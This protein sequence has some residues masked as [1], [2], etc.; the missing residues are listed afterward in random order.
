M[1]IVFPRDLEGVAVTDV[2]A[3]NTAVAV[4]SGSVPVF[5]TPALAALLEQA[6]VNALAPHLPDGMTSV[7]VHLDVQHTAATPVGMAVRARAALVRQEGRRLWFDVS[8]RDAVEPVAEG[9]HERVLVDAARFLA[10]V[11]QKSAARP[12]ALALG[13]KVAELHHSAASTGL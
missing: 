11:A 13:D 4:G 10:R 9:V 1:D 7:G 6:A 8:A 3:A 5:A 12:N 2:T